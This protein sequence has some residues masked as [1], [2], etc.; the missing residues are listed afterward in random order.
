MKEKNK[1]SAIEMKLVYVAGPYSGKNEFEIQRN[2]LRARYWSLAL[3]KSGFAVLC[4]HANTAGFHHFEGQDGIT[5][6]TWYEGDIVML[7]RCDVVFVTPN[8]KR[9]S[10]TLNE[11]KEANRL[12]IPVVYLKGE[13]PSK[14]KVEAAL[15]EAGFAF[16]HNV[17]TQV[18]S[19]VTDH[20][21]EDNQQK[22]R[23]AE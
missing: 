17:L 16:A 4:P 19:V 10:G 14:L 13:P 22:R 1:A 23:G 5:I 15:R 12:G 6:D 21:V 20:S 11:I 18:A 8:Y 7:E 3:W 9:S 2:I